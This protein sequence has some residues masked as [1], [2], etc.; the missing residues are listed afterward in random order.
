MRIGNPGSKEAIEMG[1]L[2]PPT[3]NNYGNTNTFYVDQNCPIH[4]SKPAT[5]DEL[6]RIGMIRHLATQDYLS[7]RAI[8]RQLGVSHTT[9]CN[10]LNRLGVTNK[11]KRTVKCTGCGKVLSKYRSEIKRRKKIFCSKPCYNR[12]QLLHI[13][14]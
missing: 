10:T 12:W 2:C 5:D 3:A 1:C 4:G 13:D 8:G 6:T 9:V 14:S 7:S 11:T